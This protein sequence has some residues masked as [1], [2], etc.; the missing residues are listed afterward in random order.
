MKTHYSVVFAVLLLECVLC[1]WFLLSLRAG[2]SQTDCC[3]LFLNSQL[4]TL[5]FKLSTFSCLIHS[6]PVKQVF[7]SVSFFQLGRR[8]SKRNVEWYPCDGVSSS[9]ISCPLLALFGLYVCLCSISFP[10]SFPPLRIVRIRD[11]QG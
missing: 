4:Q 6:P 9:P 10:S 5:E 7:F 8:E 3:S 11:P 2:L 1:Q